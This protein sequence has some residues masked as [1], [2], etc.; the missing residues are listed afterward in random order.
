MGGGQKGISTD[1]NCL[2]SGPHTNKP[3]FRPLPKP[4][5]YTPVEILSACQLVRN[6]ILYTELFIAVPMKIGKQVLQSSYEKENKRRNI[7]K[8]AKG[9]GELG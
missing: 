4:N 8:R 2:L 9:G 6:H 3:H 7:L 5:V 1:F